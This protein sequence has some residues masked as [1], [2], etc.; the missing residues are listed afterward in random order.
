MYKRILFFISSASNF[1]L[2]NGPNDYSGRVEVQRN[3]V[4]G[5]VCGDNFGGH[6][7]KVLCR[8]LGFTYYI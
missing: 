8:S 2:A 6:E 5:T 1:R 3:G 7:A 4:W